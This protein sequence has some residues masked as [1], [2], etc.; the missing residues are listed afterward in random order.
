[1]AGALE[2]TPPRLS[3]CTRARTGCDGVHWAA[4]GDV[5][6]LLGSTRARMGREAGR[7]VVGDEIEAVDEPS[8]RRRSGGRGAGEAIR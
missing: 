5:V 7:E 1:M 6:T 2:T 3:S 4:D 8:T